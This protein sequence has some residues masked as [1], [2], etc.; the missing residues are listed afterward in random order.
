MK[1][2]DRSRFVSTWYEQ[3][4]D[5]TTPGFV[6]FGTVCGQEIYTDDRPDGNVQVEFL[7]Y[8][9]YLE[10]LTYLNL[11]RLRQPLNCNWE[12]GR[13]RMSFFQM[14]INMEAEENFFIIDSDYDNFLTIYSCVEM[15]P[16]LFNW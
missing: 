16:G 15:I 9:P 11:V 5:W 10:I 14:P 6:H 7:T 3:R 12:T 8:W 1:N 2:V 4:N 13:C